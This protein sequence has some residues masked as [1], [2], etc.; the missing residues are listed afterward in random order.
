MSGNE[1]ERRSVTD[2][3][4]LRHARKS[5]NE[6]AEA[7]GLDP[8]E[9]LARLNEM[10]D[11]RDH[12]TVR[13]TE[14]L[15]LEEFNELL[16]DAKDRMRSA[17]DRDYAPIASVALNAV[18]K[19]SDRLDAQRKAVKIDYNKINEGQSR[20]FGRVFDVALAYIL[21]GLRKQYDIPEELVLTLH[22]EAMM[23]AAGEMQDY[24]EEDE[25]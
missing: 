4:L 25:G 16:H 22:R 1:I 14:M 7:T 21:D 8:Q 15:L 23:A 24:I 3:M 20:V 19:M 10:L 18:S 2:R 5:P 9:A 6:I 17:S 13:R 12:L 11:N